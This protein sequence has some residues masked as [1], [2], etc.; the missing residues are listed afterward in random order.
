MARSDQI[1]LMQVYIEYINDY[2]M[3]TGQKSSLNRKVTAEE[4]AENEEVQKIIKPRIEKLDEIAAQFIDA[5]IKSA[6]SV[7]Y[8][9]RWI[10]KQI[11]E[12]V[13]VIF[14]LP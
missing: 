2:E 4:A 14:F 12:L 3:K 11:S 9:I 7:P 10:C 6:D 13:K 1:G 5:L 8:G